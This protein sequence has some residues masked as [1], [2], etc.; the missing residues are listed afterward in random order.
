MFAQSIDAHIMGQLVAPPFYLTP[1]TGFLSRWLQV[2]D[3]EL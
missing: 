2:L 1:L 3:A